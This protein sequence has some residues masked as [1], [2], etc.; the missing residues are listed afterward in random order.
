VHASRH[1]QVLDGKFDL[2][3]LECSGGGLLEQRQCLAVFAAGSQGDRAV[4]RPHQR[5]EFHVRKHL[6]AEVAHAASTP[7]P[8]KL[9]TV[10]LSTVSTPIP[11]ARLTLPSGSGRGQRFNDN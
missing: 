3:A 9:L 11:S 5:A 8:L 2:P 7:K 6:L 10:H 1:R 4:T